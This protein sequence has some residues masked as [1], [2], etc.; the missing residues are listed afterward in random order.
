VESVPNTTTYLLGT[1]DFLIGSG[2]GG[3]SP[4]YVI[5]WSTLAKESI[6]DETDSRVA[7]VDGSL[8]RDTADTLSD[9]STVE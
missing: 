9:F 1:E 7:D 5:A 2:G 6:D 8:S 3:P 4:W